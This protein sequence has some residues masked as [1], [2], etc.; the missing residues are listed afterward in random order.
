RAQ[1]DDRATAEAL[2]AQAS[3]SPVTA[4][5]VDRAKAALEQATRLRAAG[6]EAHAK[7][8]DG[9]AREWAET[10]RDAA[11]AVAAE[12]L[13][14]DSKRQ[15]MQSL[16]QLQRTRALV[17]ESIARLGR[18]RAALDAAPGASAHAVEVHAG[19][20]TQAPAKTPTAGKPQAA[21]TGSTP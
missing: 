20:H 16:A 6:D 3:A 2:L 4:D 7:A 17:E 1:S 18:L 5:A 15:L 13:A 21:A 14:D 11:L 19:D 10:A 9:L 8:A 12:T